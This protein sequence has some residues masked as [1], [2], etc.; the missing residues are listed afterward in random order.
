MICMLVNAFICNGIHE[1]HEIPERCI[2]VM[3]DKT[4]FKKQLE[5]GTISNSASPIT[6]YSASPITTFLLF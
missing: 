4:V 3:T 5:Y 1:I 6:T 2:L